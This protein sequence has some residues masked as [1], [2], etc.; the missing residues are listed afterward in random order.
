[1][2]EGVEVEVQRDRTD[3]PF[4][5]VGV[6][7]LLGSRQSSCGGFYPNVDFITEIGG[8]EIDCVGGPS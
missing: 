4:A 1:V 6:Y 8:W 7:D 2:A 3:G 5:A